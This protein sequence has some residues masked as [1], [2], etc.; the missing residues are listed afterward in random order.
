MGMVVKFVLSVLR[1]SNFV[2]FVMYAVEWVCSWREVWNILRMVGRL[3]VRVMKRRV[4]GRVLVMMGVVMLW[5]LSYFWMTR[6]GVVR[7]SENESIVIR[8]SIHSIFK[9]WIP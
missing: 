3:V 8:N 5:V 7:W 4:T 9:T 1:R 6:D 2:L